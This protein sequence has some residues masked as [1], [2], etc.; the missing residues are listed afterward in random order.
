MK[1][2]I[3]SRFNNTWQ[4]NGLG[5]IVNTGSGGVGGDIA[6]IQAKGT[7]SAPATAQFEFFPSVTG[8]YTMVYQ[9]TYEVSNWVSG[10][11]PK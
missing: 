8:T 6:T 5:K 11:I 7:G 4:L 10:F 3:P 9:Y 2:P 1:I